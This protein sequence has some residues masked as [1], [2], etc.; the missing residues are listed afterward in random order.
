MGA[1]PD[2]IIEDAIK[3]LRKDGYGQPVYYLENSHTRTLAVGYG[4]QD[5]I[6]N[7][8]DAGAW[9]S[10]LVGDGQHHDE[11]QACIIAGNYCKQYCCAHFIATEII[12]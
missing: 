12:L 10:L 2:Y 3:M 1:L 7:A 9:D 5:A 11:D 4:L 6:D 8:V